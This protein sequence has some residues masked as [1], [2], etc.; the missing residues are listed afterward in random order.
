FPFSLPFTLKQRGETRQNIYNQGDVET[1]VEIIFRG[2]AL[3]PKVI[4]HTTGEFIKVDRELTSDDVL[5]ITT[6][7]GNKKVEME[8]NG[9]RENV[10]HYIDLDSTFFSLVVGDNMIEYTT[11]DELI[12]QGVEIRYYNRYLGV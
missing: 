7:F 2:P 10:F 4:N 12:S 1:P 11:E 3:N 8:S 9:V 6:H 5:Y